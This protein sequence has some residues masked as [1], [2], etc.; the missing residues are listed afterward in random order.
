MP[1][2]LVAMA[3]RTPILREYD[4]RPLGEKDVRIKS[5]LSAEKHGTTL[6]VYR[7]LSSLNEKRFDP[8]MGV[9]LPKD[10]GTG[11]ALSSFPMN[12]G[13]MTVGTV[14]ETGSG[15]TR[16]RRGDRAYGYLPIRETHAVKEDA[17]MK[18]PSE[19]RDEELVCID[20]AVVALMAVR[21]SCLRIGDAVAI[22]GGGAIGL[23]AV[24]ISKL[25][26]ALRVICIEPIEIRRRAAEK[27]GADTSL[28]PKDLDVGLEVKR[29]TEGK[30]VDISLE[31][32]GSYHA[33]QSAIRATCYGGV[34]VPVSWY[35]GEP[36]GLDLGEE[37]HFNRQ[38]MVSGAR[39]ESEPY[40]DHPRW[41]GKRVYDVVIELFRRRR[42]TAEG[43]LTPIVRL[44]DAVEA[45]RMI[46][47][48]PETTIKLGVRYG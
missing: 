42:L 40:R 20:P 37:W 30:G 11:Q 5:V 19:L 48:R 27:F 34:V 8:E 15:V 26:G 31:T 16:F 25:S 47:E 46:D 43:L 13:N 36:K 33:L 28:D 23:M 10:A 41:D 2:E 3:P 12:L 35:H 17:V 7:G 22:F 45:Y 32:S 4:E 44:E 24:Q 29:L 1:R 21:E 14:T 39:V 18:A 9:F 38:V 6:A